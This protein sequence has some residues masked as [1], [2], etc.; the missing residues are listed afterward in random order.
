MQ[1]GVLLRH[2]GPQTDADT[3]RA[4]ACA[5]EVLGYHSLWA[6]DPNLASTPLSGDGPP[7]GLTPVA[8]LIEAGAC[9]ERVQLGLHLSARG[10]GAGGW[11]PASIAR[12]PATVV[13]RLTVALD[14]GRSPVDASSRHDARIDDGLLAVRPLVRSLLVSTPS[15]ER[16]SRFAPAVDGWLL[17]QA[18]H[19]LGDSSWQAVLGSAVAE[20]RD[21][22]TLSLVV[23]ADVV[24]TDRPLR[25]RS[26]FCGSL[27]QVVDDLAEVASMGVDAA[28]L[29]VGVEL[30]LD[31][32][33]G[34]YA[35][36]AEGLEL[37]T[38]S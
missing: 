7:A 35:A 27:E 5:A 26:A 11:D 9:T 18:A 21:P 14:V 8:A 30:S 33:L 2:L 12:L 20:D 31:D 28:V 23:R 19:V 17:T 22:E 13:Q 10:G 15:R 3:V 34:A 25:R 4:A 1:L 37:R 36:I 16:W 6:T 38:R 32:V 29:A 24:L